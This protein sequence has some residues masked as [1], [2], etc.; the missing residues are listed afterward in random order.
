MS[1]IKA[2]MHQNRFPLEEGAL[3]HAPLGE[4]IALPRPSSC[5][6]RGLFLREGEKGRRLRRGE[7]KGWRE[8]RGP[9][10]QLRWGPRMV[11]PAL[12]HCLQISE[13]IQFRRSVHRLN[14]Y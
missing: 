12:L 6:L 5:I 13:R 8:G 4:F 1:D 9:A 10:L 7:R 2:K 14:C 3:P 11:N